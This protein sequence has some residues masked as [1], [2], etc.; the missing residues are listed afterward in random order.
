MACSDTKDVISNLPTDVIEI[1]LGRLPIQEAVKTSILSRKWLLNWSTLAQFVFDRQFFDFLNSRNS[2]CKSARVLNEVLLIHNGPILKFV[3]SIPDIRSQK[4]DDISQWIGLLSRKGVKELTVENLVALHRRPTHHFSCLQ[5]THLKLCSCKFYMPVI[6]SSGFQSLETLVI[7]SSTFIDEFNI[8]SPSLKHFS[9]GGELY[10]IRIA[11]APN[12]RTLSMSFSSTLGGFPDF[13]SSNMIEV[14]GRLPKLEKLYLGDSLCEYLAMRVPIWRLPAAFGCLKDIT[15]A[16]VDICNLR[17]EVPSLLCIIRSSPYLQNLEISVYHSDI[18]LAVEPE[19]SL[20]EEDCM[21]FYLQTVKLIS[22][23]GLRA[24]MKLI[25]FLL[26]CSPSLKK[27]SIERKEVP[28]AYTAALSGYKLI[29]RLVMFDRAS[30]HAEITY[31]DPS[32]PMFSSY[33]E[34]YPMPFRKFY[35]SL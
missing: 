26:A 7:E 21:L 19:L 33:T 12:L 25:E 17:D 10:Y 27:M 5:L 9:L 24:E 18:I 23:L 11:N 6:F 31:S 30:P 8:D 1:I 3:L 15:L 4:K 16:D 29:K 14:L 35:T 34:I 22:M 28:A 13:W 2:E 32:Q 20:W